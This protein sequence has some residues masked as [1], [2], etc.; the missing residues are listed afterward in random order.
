MTGSDYR[1]GV[2]GSDCLSDMRLLVCEAGR[3]GGSTRRCG[4]L[5]GVFSAVG[6]SRIRVKTM[7]SSRCDFWRIGR[8]DVK[9]YKAARWKSRR[10]LTIWK[11]H[12]LEQA[13]WGAGAKIVIRTF[14][15]LMCQKRAPLACARIVQNCAPS[16]HA[17]CFA[18]I[19]LTSSVIQQIHI[20]VP[21][22][23][24]R[25]QQQVNI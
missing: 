7:V 25:A 6:I 24:W 12:R 11:M 2:V 17:A 20:P 16:H 4:P 22:E 5:H 23:L 13:L 1:S 10:R 14:R 3:A 15:A 18:C 9:L 8:L 21:I 19:H